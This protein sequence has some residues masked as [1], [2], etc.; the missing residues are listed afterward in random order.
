M[1]KIKVMHVLTDTNIGG[2]G[3]LLYNTM[4][5]ANHDHFDYVVVL[6]RGSRLIERFRPL[7]CRVVTVNCAQDR[8]LEPLALPEYIREPSSARSWISAASRRLLRMRAV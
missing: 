7:A 4:R 1:P 3:T 2:A 8:S 5:C 6:P